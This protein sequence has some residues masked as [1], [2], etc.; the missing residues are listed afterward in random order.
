MEDYKQTS[1]GDLAFIDGDLL[2]TESTEQHQRDLIVSDKGHIRNKPEIGV[3]AV[4][5]LNDNDSSNYLRA[6]RMDFTADGMK[7]KQVALDSSGNTLID[8]EYEDS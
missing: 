3:G 4:N 1:E 5:Y 6:V 2:I 7:V 8:A